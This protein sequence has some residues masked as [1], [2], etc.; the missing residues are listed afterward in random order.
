MIPLDIFDEPSNE[1]PIRIMKS[2]FKGFLFVIYMTFQIS[3]LIVSATLILN[4]MNLDIYK[5]LLFIHLY[6]NIISTLY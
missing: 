3:L 2:S 4:D 5:A 1:T 6:F